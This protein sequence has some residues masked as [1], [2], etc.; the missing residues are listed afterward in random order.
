MREGHIPER[1]MREAVRRQEI[2]RALA[3]AKGT[4]YCFICDVEF[5]SPDAARQHAGAKHRGE[6]LTP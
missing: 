5:G 6:G 1:V 2:A 3:A 4:P